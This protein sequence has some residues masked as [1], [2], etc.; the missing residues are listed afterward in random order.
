MVCNEIISKGCFITYNIWFKIGH[1]WT[2]CD[3]FLVFLN[4]SG[5]R[6]FE[7]RVRVWSG[8][9]ILQKF[10]FGF[11]GFHFQST[12]F[13]VS[14]VPS[15]HYSWHSGCITKCQNCN[16]YTFNH[17]KLK[18]KCDFFEAIFL[19]FKSRNFVIFKFLHFC[20][21]KL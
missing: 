21:W 5:T 11:V 20:L 14:R 2:K 17:K 15:R 1:F 3:H 12:G 13:R 10:G 8:L 9:T 16:R 19:T 6:G 7:L 4:T 18:N